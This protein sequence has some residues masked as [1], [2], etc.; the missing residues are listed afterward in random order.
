MQELLDF[1]NDLPA[2]WQALLFGW[3]TVEGAARVKVFHI[4]LPFKLPGGTW[5]ITLFPF[6]LYGKGR[7]TMCIQAH[8]YEHVR[9]IRKVGPSFFAMAYVFHLA[10]GK[11]GRSHPLEVRAYEMQDW[12]EE[13]KA[14]NP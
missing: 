5:A 4:E 12:C 2:M 10:R 3:A 11:R 1:F 14:A 7:K 13:V 9:Y 6:I 8:E